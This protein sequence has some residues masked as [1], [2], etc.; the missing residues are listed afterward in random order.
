[1]DRRPLKTRSQAWVPKLARVLVRAG[2]SPNQVSVLSLGAAALAGAILAAAQRRPSLLLLA[3]A[4]IQLRLLCNLLDGVMAVE[5]GLKTKTGDLFNDIPDRVA[6]ALIL[7][8]A[9]YGT[10]CPWLGWLAALLAVMTAYLRLLGGALQLPQDFSGPMA[11]QQRMFWMTVGALGGWFEA[12]LVHHHRSPLFLKATLAW[13]T[14][15][16]AFTVG[17][18]IRRLAR[19]LEAR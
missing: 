16:T 13:V 4:G 12:L 1:M 10:G 6:D 7:V 18:R 11:K 9:G 8:G 3:A 14:L 15:G 17:R 2:F 19:A 5:A